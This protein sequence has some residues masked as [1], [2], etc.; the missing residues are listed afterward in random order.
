MGEDLEKTVL[1]G[2]LSLLRVGQDAQAGGEQ[3]TGIAFVQLQLCVACPF[4]APFNPYP[5]LF[6]HLPI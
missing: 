3:H 4:A 6:L 1:H 2:L 5:R